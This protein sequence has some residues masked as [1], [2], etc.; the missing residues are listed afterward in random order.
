MLTDSIRLFCKDVNLEKDKETKC[1]NFTVFPST[2][3][4]P[5]GYG[6][7]WLFYDEKSLKEVTEK[8]NST[9]AYFVHIWNKMLSFNNQKF[10]LIYN[11][12]A[13]YIELGKKLCPQVMKTLEKYFR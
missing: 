8:L 13:P 12:T 5:I 1:G 6:G 3:C 2:K 10:K 11:S 7:Y 9:G 4:Y